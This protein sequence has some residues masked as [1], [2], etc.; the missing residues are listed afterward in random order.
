[1]TTCV[2]P[3]L[4]QAVSSLRSVTILKSGKPIPLEVSDIIALKWA[5]PKLT[6]L[7]FESVLVDFQ[8]RD[9][10][11]AFLLLKNEGIP[12]DESLGKV[13]RFGS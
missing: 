7:L 8:D 13:R 10:E 2:T 4:A 11:A 6:I 3:A 5:R 9:A 12:V 1:M